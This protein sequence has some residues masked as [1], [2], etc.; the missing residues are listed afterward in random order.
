MQAVGNQQPERFNRRQARKHSNTIYEG[1]NQVRSTRMQQNETALWP[2]ECKRAG[3]PIRINAFRN[4]QYKREIAASTRAVWKSED[5]RHAACTQVLALR[6][7][8]R[9]S[10][11]ENV[12]GSRHWASDPS[13]SCFIE[14]WLASQQLQSATVE[15]MNFGNQQMRNPL[16]DANESEILETRTRTHKHRH[17]RMHS[18][19]Y[20]RSHNRQVWIGWVY[21]RMDKSQGYKKHKFKKTPR[22]N[23][24]A[25][26]N[27]RGISCICIR[28]VICPWRTLM[29][30]GLEAWSSI[31]LLGWDNRASV[32]YTLL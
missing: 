25:K 13:S 16:A 23:L 12:A 17:L 26:L 27:G 22:F 4:I 31:C 2:K 6:I 19:I 29:G 7:T 8:W 30:G 18:Y 21:S 24:L 15:A 14:W 1:E 10:L 9:N 28:S 32:Q 20:I 5:R 3:I 11:R